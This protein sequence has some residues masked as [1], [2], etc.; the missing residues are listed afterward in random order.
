MSSEPIDDYFAFDRSGHVCLLR[1][2][3]ELGYVVVRCAQG[4]TDHEVQV[5]AGR[6]VSTPLTTEA[7]QWLYEQGF[8]RKRAS[9]NFRKR[10][11][12]EDFTRAQLTDLLH[13]VF[14]H[15]FQQIQGTQSI[16][17]LPSLNLDEKMVVDAMRHLAKERNWAARKTLY[18]LLIDT[19]FLVPINDHNEPL[20][21]DKMGSFPVCA[22]FTS[23]PRLLK[24]YPEGQQFVQRDGKSLFPE[25]AQKRF[26]SMRINPR[27]E[28][29][30]EL[31]LN[32]LNMLVQGIERLAAHYGTA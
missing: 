3:S 29:G 19:E 18:R 22:V 17:V 6:Q 28:V 5:S 2:A 14:E 32:E 25:L 9:E 10:F 15:C 12:R 21:V 27:T 30:G 26:G 23:M 1:S 24:A 7:Q 8:R 31:Y 13:S 4:E 16:L 11:K 20:E